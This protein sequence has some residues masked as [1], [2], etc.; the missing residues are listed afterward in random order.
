M[1]AV[2]SMPVLTA[3]QPMSDDDGFDLQRHELGGHDVD[4]GDAER[5]LRGQAVM[6][7]VPYTP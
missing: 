7:E 2:A 1:A 5:V 3:S 4:A 6:A